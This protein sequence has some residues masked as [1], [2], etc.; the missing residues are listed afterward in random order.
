MNGTHHAS[1][2]QIT[3]MI[4]VTKAIPTCLVKVP[5][6]GINDISPLAD[7]AASTTTAIVITVIIK[8]YAVTTRQTNLQQQQQ[9]SARK[10][11]QHT[12]LLSYHMFWHYS[13]CN[14]TDMTKLMT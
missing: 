4:E 3:V 11:T 13:L 14:M 5:E 8:Y 2:A 7:F 10:K 6:L 1:S 12:I 9:W